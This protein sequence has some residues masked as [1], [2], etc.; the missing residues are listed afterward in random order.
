MSSNLVGIYSGNTPPATDP[1]LRWLSS[2]LQHMRV[3]CGQADRMPIVGSYFGQGPAQEPCPYWNP[4]LLRWE[5]LVHQ[6]NQQYW[7]YALTGS[8]MGAW[9][10]PVLCLGN[11]VGG[12][13]NFAILANVY[14]ENNVIYCTYSRSS[15]SSAVY[16]ASA[17]MPTVAGAMPAFSALG[18]VT[19]TTSIASK[20]LLNQH[21]MK[22]PD[23]AYLMLSESTG[24]RNVV[25]RSEAV[26]PAQWVASP[27]VPVIVQMQNGLRRPSIGDNSG[28][29]VV[30]AYRD[31]GQ[32]PQL[33]NENGT[34]VYFSS[35]GGAYFN[36]LRYRRATSTQADSYPSLW[37]PDRD[38]TLI[39]YQHPLEQDQLVDVQLA[40]AGEDGMWFAFWAAN[41]NSSQAP[42]SGFNIMVAPMHQPIL[43]WDGAAWTPCNA[44]GDNGADAGWEFQDQVTSSYVSSHLDDLVVDAAV[45]ANVVI[46]LPTGVTRV[47]VRI[48]NTA[49]SGTNQVGVAV[50]G[51]NK[52]SGGN[53]I[54]ALSAV[55]T[56]VTAVTQAAHGLVTGDRVTVS[57]STPTAYNVTSTACTVVDSVTFTY[58]AGSA[59]AVNTVLGVFDRG[60]R[61][62]ETRAYVCNKAGFF[63]RLA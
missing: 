33:F 12:E 2:S 24:N 59:P 18:L 36:Y 37:T 8:P 25:L 54:T 49:D 3:A 48:S 10:T 35:T 55:G 42:N 52:V 23:G 9:S 14:I 46:T 19:N 38:D 5:I 32:R 7:S 40:Q 39:R 58:V 43:Q 30:V 20:T 50:Q 1:R 28:N 26:S 17:P 51:T 6:S 57:G 45:N 62:G 41:N 63:S 13:A 16:S 47:R 44:Q 34:W 4:V 15:S 21:V 11:G 29:A 27:F 22:A 56:T 60:L 31:G 61:P 53:P